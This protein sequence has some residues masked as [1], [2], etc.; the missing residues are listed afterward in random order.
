MAG[1]I[2]VLAVITA[3]V[4]AAIEFL[5]HVVAGFSC[6]SWVGWLAVLILAV[7]ACLEHVGAYRTRP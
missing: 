2:I 3:A 7:I 4:L 5:A 1:L 6:P